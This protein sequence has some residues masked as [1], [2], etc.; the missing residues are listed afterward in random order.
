[1]IL[2]K[3]INLNP[4]RKI[5]ILRDKL[6]PTRIITKDNF[7]NGD[8]LKESFEQYLN[9]LSFAGVMT[10]GGSGMKQ[11][12]WDAFMPIID[13]IQGISLPLCFVVVATAMCLIIVGQKKQGMVM[14][15]WAVIGFIAMQWLPSFM[16]ILA[17]VGE[18]M[19]Q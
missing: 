5:N 6:R 1:M 12:I 9:Q 13:V 16:K 8:P 18:A 17:E 15:K 7:A 2:I 3:S 11:K 10:V 4:T 19:G 14:A